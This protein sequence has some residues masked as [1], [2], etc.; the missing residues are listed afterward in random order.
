MVSVRRIKPQAPGPVDVDSRRLGHT[1]ALDHGLTVPLDG[2]V[3]GGHD[4]AVKTCE[5]SQRAIRG[6]RRLKPAVA[7]RGGD[8]RY[9][10]QRAIQYQ[11]LVTRLVDHGESGRQ[12]GWAVG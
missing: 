10:R 5:G 3:G 4:G 7:D 8:P 9:G 11:Q 1:L 2:P 12:P 6:D